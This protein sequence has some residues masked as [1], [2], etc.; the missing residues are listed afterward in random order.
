[1]SRQVSLHKRA[2]EVILNQMEDMGE[3]STEEVMDL[4]RP[5]FLF[6]VTI[7]REQTIRRKANSIMRQFRDENGNRTCF[8]YKDEEGTSLYANVDT[9]KNLDA[10]IGIE[11]QLNKKFYGL[12]AAKRKVNKRRKEIMGQITLQEVAKW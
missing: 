5:H 6:D 11:E 10:L 8:N 12:N 4:I 2:K 1:M 3:I 9:T 7:A